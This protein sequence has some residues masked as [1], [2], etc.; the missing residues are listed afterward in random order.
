ML[1]YR[2]G[3]IGYAQSSK[4][5]DMRRVVHRFNDISSYLDTFIF[6]DLHIWITSSVELL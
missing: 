2:E 1:V 5:R 3:F 4:E 6:I